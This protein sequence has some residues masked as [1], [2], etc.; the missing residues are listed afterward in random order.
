MKS[1]RLAANLIAPCGANCGIC[2]AFF[3]YRLDGEKRKK[4]C[5][6]CRSRTSLCAFIKKCCEKLSKN[7][8]EY[9][10]ECADF[11]CQ[12]LKTLDR[13]YRKNY[14]MSMIENLTNIHTGGIR[15]FLEE[16]KERWKC[17]KCG[18]IVCVHNR[19]CYTCNQTRVT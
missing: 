2:V 17:P 5:P 10:F 11:P 8:V 14:G 12:R 3:G 19:K 16:E 9:C 18:G 4:A 6:G 7:Q 1:T 13:R 15:R